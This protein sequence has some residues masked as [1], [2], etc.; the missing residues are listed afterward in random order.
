[1]SALH[2]GLGERLEFVAPSGGMF[3]WVRIPGVEDTS[4]WLDRCLDEGVCFVPGDAFA[5]TR[6]LKSHVRLSFAT[7]SST[8]LGEAVSRMER[9]LEKL[10]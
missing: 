8:E 3:V 9:A 5:V 7:G 1:M 4:I 2:S 6:N 10:A